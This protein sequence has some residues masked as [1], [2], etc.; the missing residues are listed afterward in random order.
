MDFDFDILFRIFI[1][2]LK[3]KVF[4]C[5]FKIKNFK[6]KKSKI[7]VYLFSKCTSLKSLKLLEIYIF[8]D[9][10]FGNRSET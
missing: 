5:K 10:D 3:K 4:V 1:L 2:N 9:G 6:K 8:F 7:S